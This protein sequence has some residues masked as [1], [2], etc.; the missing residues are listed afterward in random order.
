MI[1]TSIDERTQPGGIGLGARV[2]LRWDS[3][4]TAACRL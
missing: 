1:R 3:W 2:C 4:R